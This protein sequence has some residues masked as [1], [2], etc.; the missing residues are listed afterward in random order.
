MLGKLGN[1]AVLCAGIA[2]F[3]AGPPALAGQEQPAEAPPPQVIAGE[4]LGGGNGLSFASASGDFSF[5]IGFW[6]QFRFQLYDKDQWRR[7]SR[8]ILT[9]PIPV[10]NIGETQETFDVPRLRLY[11]AGNTFKPWLTYRLETDL[12][13]DDQGLREVF[14]PACDPIAGCNA[15]DIRAGTES[16]DGRTLKLVDFYLDGAPT[17]AA[18]FRVGQFKVPHSRQELVSDPRLQMTTRSI[19]SLFFAP[20]RDRGIEAK[21][22]T[23]KTQRIGYQVGVFNG[24]GLTAKNN[25]DATLAYDFRLTLTSQGPYL[26]IESLIDA[27]ADRFHAQGGVSWYN[28]RMRTFASSDPTSLVGDINDRRVAAD[29]QLF[30]HR[31]AN[32]LAEYYTGSIR[33]DDAIQQ[34]MQFIC[35]G[36]YNQGLLT[37][38]Q[39]GYYVQGGATI[40][41]RSEIS[42]RYSMVDADRDLDRDRQIETTLNYTYFFRRHALRWSTS[43]TALTLEVNA[44]N[45]SGLAV[46]SGDASIPIISPFPNP[47]AFPGLDDDH[48]RLFV[49]QLQWA[50]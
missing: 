21:G 37:C 20:G 9:P 22:A 42:A 13:A 34:R 4:D 3:A 18:G 32:L 23:P 17:V 6:G 49:T 29:L 25:L 50:F 30:W 44:P 14:I 11:F 16:Q 1:A 2:L 27:P 38:D 8:T 12:V 47:E 31:H 41:E 48:N 19:A 43:L 45:A 24:T 26:D 33:V 28:S 40:G 39:K 36:A 35:F 7:T 46:Q 15:V 5:R 10:E